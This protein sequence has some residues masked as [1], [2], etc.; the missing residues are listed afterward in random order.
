MPKWM[1]PA[2]ILIVAIGVLGFAEWDRQDTI[3]RA[4]QERMASLEKRVDEAQRPVIHIERAT[5]YNM[6]GELVV[7]TAEKQGVKK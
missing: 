4:M 7:D 3:D 5:V 6:D 2:M 1:Y